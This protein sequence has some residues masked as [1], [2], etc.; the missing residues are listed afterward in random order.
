MNIVKGFFLKVGYH[1]DQLSILKTFAIIFLVSNSGLLFADKYPGLS[2]FTFIA[3]IVIYLLVTEIYSYLK[4]PIMKEIIK[5]EARKEY[6]RD[7]G[8]DNILEFD[9]KVDEVDKELKPYEDRFARHRIFFI[10][11]LFGILIFLCYQ[12]ISFSFR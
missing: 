4:S 3:P 1:L 7:N 9:K 2:I 11:A 10:M 5:E 8:T 6:I 12:C